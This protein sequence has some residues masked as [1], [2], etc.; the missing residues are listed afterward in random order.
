[1]EFWLSFNN[2][3]EKLRLP[4]PP[5]SFEVKTGLSNQKLTIIEVG[6]INLIGKKNVNAIS[7]SSFFPKQTYSFCQYTTFPAPYNCVD[8]IEKWKASGKPIRLIITGTSVNMACVIDSFSYGERDASGDVYFSLELS[9]YVFLTAKKSNATTTSK[10]TTNHKK[11]SSKEIPKTVTVKTGDT[12][13]GIAIKYY[14]DSS[15]WLNIKKNN[16]I[17][18]EKKLVVG[19]VLKL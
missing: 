18:D 2:G 8:L 14:N 12:L 1:M 15:K 5:S 13:I 10:N 6:E 17:K 4:V 3:Q 9:E 16:G 11:Q 19:M 7:I